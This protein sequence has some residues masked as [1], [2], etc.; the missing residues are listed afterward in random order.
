MEQP[1]LL[2]IS[3]T[4]TQYR[5]RLDLPDGPLGQEY[6]IDLTTEVRERLR[7]ALQSAF[8]S[9][10]VMDLK[11]PTAK[12]GPASDAF[13]SLGRFLFESILPP[14]LQDSLRR[15]D[16]AL[17][18][19]T[20][21]P[22]IPWELLYDA[23]TKNR[24]YLCHTLNVGRLSQ[25]EIGVRSLLR[26]SVKRDVQGLSVLFLVN[27]TS[28]RPAAE[29]EVAALCTNLPEAVSRIILYRQQANQL[30]I[31]MRLSTE[32]PHV[33]HYA[34]PAPMAGNANDPG[35]P[36]AG[37]SRLDSSSLE[38]LLQG[39]PKPP[40]VF[41]SQHEEE[42]PF[43]TGSLL[44]QQEHDEQQERLASNFLAAGASAVIAARWP[45]NQQRAHEFTTLFYQDVADGVAVGEALRRARVTMAQRYIDDVS[46]MS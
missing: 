32:A 11:R 9:V 30:E 5:F 45:I 40:L 14:P 21:T 24:R 19:S 15:L 31:R 37:N 18:F 46:W 42:R 20:N 35:L 1:A 25:R 6:T 16:G 10:Q 23:S 22:D 36:L 26:K 4:E 41:L 44:L 13:L 29:E 33:L 12:L 38:Q 43:R 2:N 34:G 17:I 27:P 3:R 28:E 7:R 39:L 8:Q